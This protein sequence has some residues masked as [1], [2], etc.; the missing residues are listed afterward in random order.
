[1]KQLQISVGI[2]FISRDLIRHW[3]LKGS[4]LPVLIWVL[5]PYNTITQ[6][7]YHASY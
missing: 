2:I 5:Y 7:N 1:M 6:G 3:T 4:E